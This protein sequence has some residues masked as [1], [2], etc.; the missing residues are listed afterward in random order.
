MLF[1]LEEIVNRYIILKYT[2]ILHTESYG[3]LHF[4]IDRDKS[5]STVKICSS[6]GVSIMRGF[7]NMYRHT[8]MYINEMFNNVSYILDRSNMIIIGVGQKYHCYSIDNPYRCFML[9][10]GDSLLQA[11][12]NILLTKFVVIFM[13]PLSVVDKRRI[14]W[15]NEEDMHIQFLMLDP[16]HIFGLASWLLFFNI[17]IYGIKYKDKL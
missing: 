1:N 14:K 17:V 13:K 7:F 3:T 2:T 11:T 6:V 10:K 4:N 9:N 15:T 8:E 5:N 12:E 16:K